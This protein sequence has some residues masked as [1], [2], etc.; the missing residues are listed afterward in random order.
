MLRVRHPKTGK[1][2]DSW[3]LDESRSD[4]CP[5]VKRFL[6]SLPPP[7]KSRWHRKPGRFYV[8][9][10]CPMPRGIKPMR[11]CRRLDKICED[12]E[13]LETEIQQHGQL[14]LGLSTAQRYVASQIF[15]IAERLKVDALEVFREFEKS[16]PHGANARTLD[17]VRTELVEWKK[18]TGRSERHVASLDYRLRKLVKA[19]GDKPVTAITTQDLEAELDRH[20]DWNATTVHSVVQGWKIALNFAV[21]RGYALKNPA[22]RLE[23]PKIVHDEPRVLTVDEARRLLAATLFSDR[24]PLLPA[25]RA[26][27]AIGMFAGIRPEEMERLEWSHVM[28]STATITIKFA[29]AKARDRRIV[30]IAPN[31]GRWL[32]PLAKQRGKVLTQPIED[33]RAAARGVLGLPK[34]PSDVLRHTYA[35]YHYAMHR[36]EQETKHQMVP[37]GRWAAPS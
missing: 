12:V 4:G 19:I 8:D 26:Y 33:L 36:N 15:T 11:L 10:L 37:S 13:R 7:W 30:D 28:L 21:R 25:C 16:H 20:C 9:A 5:P 29:N 22:D 27:L 23:L 3:M 31:L 2:V 14:A 1:F 18:K 32:Q 24:H 6:P 17:Q 34:W 35:S